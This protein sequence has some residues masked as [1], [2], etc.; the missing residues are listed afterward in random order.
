MLNTT[1]L[2]NRLRWLWGCQPNA[3]A[4]LYSPERFLVVICVRGWV[5]PRAIVRMMIRSTFR[6]VACYCQGAIGENGKATRTSGKKFSHL[7]LRY[8]SWLPYTT[9]CPFHGVMHNKARGNFTFAI[10]LTTPISD[11]VASDVWVNNMMKSIVK[12]AQRS[13]RSLIA[14]YPGILQEELWKH[15]IPL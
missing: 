14:V 6:L 10:Y 4:A 1:L 12:N 11:C 5:D 7:H 3:L 8:K 2:D 9:A 15:K 13:D